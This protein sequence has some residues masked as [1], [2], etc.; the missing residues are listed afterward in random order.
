MAIDDQPAE[1]VDEEIVGAAVM[2]VFD[3]ADVLEMVIDTLDQD[4]FAQE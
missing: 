2:S 4:A 3:V 1:E